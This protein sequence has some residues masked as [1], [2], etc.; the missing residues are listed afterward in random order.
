MS[1]E[2]KLLY[3]ISS[4]A[5]VN[6]WAL[7][8][9]GNTTIKYKLLEKYEPDVVSSMAIN[10]VDDWVHGYKLMDYIT[11]FDAMSNGKYNF[12]FVRNPIARFVSM[13]KDFCTTRSIIKAVEGLSIDAFIDYLE[14]ELEAEI[15]ANIHF[16][17]QQYFLEYFE[18]DIF[19]IDDYTQSKLN[20]RAKSVELTTQQRERVERLYINDYKYLDNVTDIEKFIY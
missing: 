4:I 13:Y 16:R 15:C 9:C 3:S 17:T 10:G 6:Y 14:V 20:H 19:N 11:P 7:P 12:T 8:K 5:N 1:L 18:G 2:N